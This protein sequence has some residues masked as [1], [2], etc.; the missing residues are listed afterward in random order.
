[1][2][3]FIIIA[4]FVAMLAALFACSAP[5]VYQKAS[6]N[7]LK[8]LLDVPSGYKFVSFDVNNTETLRDQVQDRLTY[9]TSDQNLRPYNY[10]VESARERLDRAK[11]TKDNDSIKLCQEEYDNAMERLRH[12]QEVISFLNSQ[13]DKDDAEL[14]EIEA[15]NCKLVYEAPNVLGV[16]LQQVFY[17]RF[18]KN[19]QL[20]AYKYQ[21]N[22][23]TIIKEYFS[24][25][26]FTEIVY[27]E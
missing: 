2:K 11:K 21:D 10:S 1:M 3:R 27:R 20:I 9:F 13:L 18:D 19:E 5:S 23:W 8:G 16:P 26:G 25:P 15:Y 7:Y 12:E 17:T 24:I 6:E 4:T 22:N 14:N